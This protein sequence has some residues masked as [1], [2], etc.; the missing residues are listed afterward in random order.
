[1]NICIPL[2]EINPQFVLFTTPVPNFI[3]ANSM[4]VQ[5][6]YKTPLIELSQIYAILNIA[7]P[8]TLISFQLLE[9]NI[10]QKYQ[11]I[12]PKTKTKHVDY[13]T[14]IMGR[15][16]RFQST[17]H[18]VYD[19]TQS[20]ISSYKFIIKITGVWETEQR[21]GIIYKFVYS[22]QPSVV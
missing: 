7:D 21:Y 6:R 11:Q 9:K 20:N 16:Q 17:I 2:N 18:Q 8:H 12:N 5:L 15:F 19:R 4:F 1:M 10:L 22:F 14:N 3:K 13:A